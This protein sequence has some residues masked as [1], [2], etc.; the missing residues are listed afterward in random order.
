MPKNSTIAGFWN[1]FS[2]NADQIRT[3]GAEHVRD[4]IAPELGERLKECHPRLVWEIAADS[5][6]WELCISA[7]GDRDAFPAVKEV[8][9]AAP[10]IPGWAIRAFRQRGKL[11]VSLEFAGHKLTYDDIWFTADRV[12]K[13]LSVTLWIKGLTKETD[14]IL[15]Q[16]ALILLDNALGEY[17]AVVHIAELNRGPLPKNPETRPG[18]HP[19]SQLPE[20]VDFIKGG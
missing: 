19:L 17:D 10:T 11:D 13:G 7:D 15:R 12:G 4:G 16:A 6:V 3:A 9:E 18:L 14:Q 20:M 5:D 2:Q 8:V 1:W